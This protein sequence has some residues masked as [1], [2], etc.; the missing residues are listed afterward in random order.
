MLKMMLIMMI[1]KL[2]HRDIDL[3]IKLSNQF[4]KTTYGIEML[5][6]DNNV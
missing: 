2:M 6:T 3:I 5:F 1:L 4:V